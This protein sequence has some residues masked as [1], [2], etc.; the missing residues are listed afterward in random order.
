MAPRKQRANAP[1]AVFIIAFLALVCAGVAVWYA[2]KRQAETPRPSQLTSL[3]MDEADIIAPYEHA[4][5]AAQLEALE[6]A[7]GPQ[8]VVA[9]EKRLQ[10]ATIAEDGLEHARRWKIGHAGRNDGV[11]LLIVES[12]RK[13][14]IEVGYGLEGVLTDAASRLIID[15][16]MQAHLTA[17]EWTEAARGGLDGI[18]EVV[19]PAGIEPPVDAPYMGSK[20]SRLHDLGQMAGMALFALVAILIP[21]GIIQAFVLAIPGVDQRLR[22]SKRWGWIARWRVLSGS[23]GGGSSSGGGGS[24]GGGGGGA[25]GGGGSFGG[26]GASN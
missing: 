9:T 8:I 25:S 5:M 20:P 11:L 2:N 24:G 15:R 6:A 18:L 19:H 16:R 22:R 3:V 1:Q 23:S 26:G 14:R 10:G 4:N 21:L 12:E 17:G 13:A 7:G